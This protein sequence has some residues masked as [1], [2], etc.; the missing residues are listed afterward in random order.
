MLGQRGYC[1]FRGILILA[2]FFKAAKQEEPAQ[3]E[4]ENISYKPWL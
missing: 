4:K 2:G 3:K 1:N